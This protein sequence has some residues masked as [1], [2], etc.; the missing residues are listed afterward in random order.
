M[1]EKDN[2]MNEI[3]RVKQN[4]MDALK[5][6]DLTESKAKYLQNEQ[7]VFD[8]QERK[9]TLDTLCQQKD[10][11]ISELQE[12][13]QEANT[14]CQVNEKTLSEMQKSLKEANSACKVNDTAMADLK[15]HCQQ[16]DTVV[17]NLKT[18]CK[19][20]DAVVDDMKARCKNKDGVVEDMR[21]RLSQANTRA[22]QAEEENKELQEIVILTK[23]KLESVTSECL[24]K[25]KNLAT[26]QAKLSLQQ[27]LTE[28]KK[29]KLCQE[30]DRRIT[31]LQKKVYI[32]Q[33][34]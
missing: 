8:L 32:H 30:K 33:L 1:K 11:D 15:A 10:N 24:D 5:M 21:K 22:N 4:Q 25:D 6:Q 20:K 26:L 13:L 3:E 28:A 27:N 23:T 17:D 12:R 16:N 7:S 34:Y 18:R 9:T 14:R 2:L 19:Q 29:Q 31:E